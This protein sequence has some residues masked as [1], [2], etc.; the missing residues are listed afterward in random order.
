MVERP[1]VES[2]RAAG[3]RPSFRLGRAGKCPAHDDRHASLSINEGDDGRVLVKCHAGCSVDAV[4]GAFGLSKRDLFPSPRPAGHRA[5]PEAPKPPG[6]KA[7]E[8]RR[9]DERAIEAYRAALLVDVHWLERL[10]RT[11]GWSREAVER[12]GVGLDGDRVV[13]PYRDAAG[14][15]VGLA[16]YQPDPGLRQEAPKLHAAPGSRRELFPPPEE[17]DGDPVFLAEGEAD[18]LAALSVGLAA[19]AVPGVACWRREWRERFSGRRVVSV[20]DCDEPGRAAASQIAAD[21]VGVAAEVRLVDLD[22]DRS[23]GYDLTDFLLHG[24]VADL[25]RLV[26]EARL[27]EPTSSKPVQS[28]SMDAV[29]RDTFAFLKKHLAVDEPV[30]ILLAIWAAHTHAIDCFATTPYLHI[31]STEPSSGKT[32]VLELLELLVR[33]PMRGSNLSLA[34]LYRAIDQLHPTLLLDEVD[35]LL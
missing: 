9:F 14:Q 32:R 6:R 25:E 23:D 24:S 30:Y 11:R 20:F 22:P 19:V 29:L 7:A 8:P 12:F 34:V 1:R 21:L 10:E 26:H 2:S 5:R 27:W 33:D 16:R 4:L 28:D 13:F 17:V 18:A 15:L 31:T 3:R 35:N